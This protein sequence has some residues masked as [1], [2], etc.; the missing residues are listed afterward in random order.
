[1]KNILRLINALVII[2]VTLSCSDFT[3]DI[4]KDNL[5]AV[6]VT[7]DGATTVGFN[8]YYT[9]SF[10]LD[11]FSI[12]LRI[13]ASSKLKIKEVTN[14]VTGTT[15]INV[16]SLSGTTGQYLTS[17]AQVGGTYYKLSTSV[18]EF[19][20]KVTGGTKIANPAAGAYAERAFMIK[21]T[22]DD[23]SLIVPVQCRIRVF[24]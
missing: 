10:A 19:N 22:M 11:T 2:A 9:V 7:Y 1:M 16:A 6:P 18:T 24:R 5:A 3:G 21:L 12:R 17:P 4:V 14:I 23:N 13:P 8:P 20:T 15:A